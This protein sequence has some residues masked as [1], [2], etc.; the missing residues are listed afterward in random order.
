MIIDIHSR[1]WE[2]PQHFTDD[3]RAQA[4]RARAGVEVDLT[5]RYDE[6]MQQAPPETRTIISS[7]VREKF[8]R[9]MFRMSKAWV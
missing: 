8:V 6:Y 1:V 5:V 9:K 2:Y 4:S 7:D 3:F